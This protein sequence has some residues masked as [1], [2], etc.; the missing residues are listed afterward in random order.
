M[1]TP[2]QDFL[3]FSNLIKNIINKICLYGT[4]LVFPIGFVLNIFSIIIFMRKRFSVST[5]GF[6]NIFT[7]IT[8]N[9]I[10]AFNFFIYFT[11]GLDNDAVLMSNF[12]CGFL[13]YTS[14]VSTCFA[15]WLNLMVNFDRMLFVL[16]PNKFL[17][18]KN[19]KILL[20]ILSIL[21]ITASFI[22]LPNL[23]FKITTEYI[24]SNKTGQNITTLA[25]SPPKNLQVLI[26]VTRISITALIPSIL[27]LVVNSFLINKLIKLRE[28]VRKAVA[29]KIE[30]SF[31]KSIAAITLF[32]IFSVIPFF[33][34]LSIMSIMAQF[35][36]SSTKIY[37]IMN[38]LYALSLLVVSYNYCFVFFINLIYN[39]LFR[40]ETI[41]FL[42]ELKNSLCS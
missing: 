19:K 25:C 12:L 6:Y 13:N 26:N 10:I 15:S 18:L 40:L 35:N 34:T 4:M 29:L 20:I 11:Q 21:F 33:I 41:K 37:L 28:K 39:S 2:D 32:T 17:F 36:L 1:S 24:Y 31:A 23:Y 16:F 27:G 14:R 38:V 5:M 7:A 22:N 30:Y 42:R 3:E 8:N 9:M